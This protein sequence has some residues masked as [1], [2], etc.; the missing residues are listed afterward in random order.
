VCLLVFAWRVH[1]QLPLIVAGNRDEFHDRPTAAAGWWSDRD[2]VLAGRDLQAG[3]SWLGVS[4]DGRI[5]VVTNYR[6][7]ERGTSGPR[8]RGELVVDFLTSI[9]SAGQWMEALGRR[10]AEY[11]GFN[12]I[13]G[14]RDGLHYL[15]NRGEDR[16]DLEPGL[17]GLSNHRLDT[18]WPKVRAAKEGLRRRI[19][20]GDLTSDSLFALLADRRPAPDAELPK[21]GVPADWERLLSSAFIVS[22][23]YGTRAGTVV[24]GRGDGAVVFE[25]RRF[26]ADGTLDGRARFE[27]PGP[28]ETP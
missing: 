11:A 2:G 15:T 25:E 19:E 17:Y 22:P 18:P 16:R 12:L 4:R 7:P 13:V 27:V 28:P 23:R 10:K 8:S 5:A 6:E 9:T 14:D 26:A 3:G 20:G 24:L 21:T 1:P